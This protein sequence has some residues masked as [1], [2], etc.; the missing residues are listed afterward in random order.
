[1]GNQFV[2]RINCIGGFHTELELLR[3]LP[4]ASHPSLRKVKKE[5]GMNVPL[6]LFHGV[7]VNLYKSVMLTYQVKCVLSSSLLPSVVG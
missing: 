4:K 7:S 1:M 3:N 5:A 2:L 6:V